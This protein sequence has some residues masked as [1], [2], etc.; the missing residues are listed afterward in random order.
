MEKIQHKPKVLVVED[1]LPILNALVDKLTRQEFDVLAAKNGQE[2]L[3]IALKER[4]DVILVDML[5]PI[6]DGSTMMTK[7]RQEN[8]WGKEVPIM[9]L[10]NLSTAEMEIIKAV[11]EAEPAYYLVKSNWSLAEVVKK[12]RKT[13]SRKR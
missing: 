8:E 11:I 6:M 4:P 3:T 2:G 10:T 7:L 9:V 13:L 5:M 12:V 1:D